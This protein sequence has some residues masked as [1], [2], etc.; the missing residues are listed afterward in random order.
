MKKENEFSCHFGH[1][2]ISNGFF[3]KKATKL[4]F[5]WSNM[6]QKSIK[7]LILINAVNYNNE[8]ERI[9]ETDKSNKS[10]K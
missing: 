3:Y 10:K 7:V 4:V 6:G 8:S 9:Y 5:F 2:I 1:N